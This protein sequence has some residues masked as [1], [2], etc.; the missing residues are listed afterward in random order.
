MA[1]S[2]TGDI[3]KATTWSIVLSVLMIAA[4]VL[5]IFSPAIAGVA[6]TVFF[7]WL[8]IFSGI[9]H[10]AFAWQAGRAGAVVWEILVGMLYG[11]I[12]FYL[13]ARPVA[14]LESLT[15]AL[16]IYLVMEGVLEFILSFQLRPVAGQRVAAVRRH[17]DAGACRD[18]RERLA[19]QLGLGDRH[20]RRRQHVLQRHHAADALD[21]RAPD[22]G[23]TAGDG[24]AGRSAEAVTHWRSHAPSRAAAR[25]QPDLR[26]RRSCGPTRAVGDLH[27]PRADAAADRG[28]R[29][30]PSGREGPLVGRAVRGVRVRRGARGRVTRHVSRGRA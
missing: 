1:N 2:I 4:G 14:G 9:L 12:G 24:I 23:V 16:A 21:R 22:R 20:A 17:R 18:D 29:R 25:A 13:L 10:L 19:D 27:G 7:G 5:A 8:L 30:R 28:H 15:L 11:G 26:R 6:V 3:H